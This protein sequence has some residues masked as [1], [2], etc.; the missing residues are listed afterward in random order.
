MITAITLCLL[1][2]GGGVAYAAWAL[3][4]YRHGVEPALLAL[5][6]AGAYLALFGIFATVW[7]LLAWAYRA[8]R[9]PQAQIGFATTV[10]M[11][12]EE[13]ITLAGSALRMGFGWWFMRDPPATR[14]DRPVLLVHGVLC[15]AGVWLGMR[16]ALSGMGVGP[17][18]TISL[19]SPL[20]S[21][22]RFAEQVAARID[23]I[24]AV[25]GAPKIV[26]V[27]HSMGGLVARAYV[28]AYGSNRVTRLVT[29]GT[30]HRG[31]VVARGVPGACLGQMCPGS[32]WLQG[33][34]AAARPVI[35]VV[36][37]WSWHDSMVVPQDSSQLAGAT[38]I[39]VTGVGHNALLRNRRVIRLV[40]E[41]L[42]PERSPATAAG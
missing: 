14:A 19:R 33:L 16:G 8:Q 24:L 42:A 1:L 5:G 7:F 25:T 40:A 27:G 12:T 37:I 18:Y 31:S 15:N 13:W 17:I 23:H 2:L 30:P 29:I 26:I 38:N 36:S 11:F 32:E 28:R 20:A 34:N 10:R 21:I 39:T 22:D 3:A 4:A 6:A 41:A 9:P 35:P